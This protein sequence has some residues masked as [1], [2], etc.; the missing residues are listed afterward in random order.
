MN[1]KIIVVLAGTNNIGRFPANDEKVAD[2]TRG[3]K[4][5]LDTCRSKAPEATIIMT[6]IFPRND[7]LAVMPTIN[8]INENV[9]AFCDGKKVRYLNVNDKLADRRWQIVRGDDE[10]SRQTA[11]DGEGVPGLGRRIKTDL[12]RSA[13]PPAKTDHAPAPTGDPSA[14]GAPGARTQTEP[15]PPAK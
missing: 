1:P 8:K 12:H 13:W 11:P 14:A 5:I 3:L 7:N 10:R 4:A 2:I 15:H 9:A 6:A